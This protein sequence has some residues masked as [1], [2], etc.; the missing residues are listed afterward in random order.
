MTIARLRPSLL[1]GLA[2][3]T[4]AG[5]GARAA[6]LDHIQASQ[7][8][9]LCAHPDMLP[10]SKQSEPPSGFQV[11]L[12]QA[13]ADRLG[14]ELDISW[15]ISRRSASKTGCDLYAGVAR[16]DDAPSKYLKLTDAFMRMESVLVTAAHRPALHSIT[17]LQGMTVGVAPGSVAAH[18]LNQQG[19]RTST[20]FLDESKRLQALLNHAIDAAVVT[21]LSAGWLQQ[22]LQ[23][24]QEDDEKRAENEKHSALNILDAEQLLG[25]RLNYDYAL[26]LRK[27]DQSTLEH[28]NALLAEMKADGS[29]AGLLRH[30][31]LDAAGHIALSSKPIT[32]N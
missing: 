17:D 23:Q 14:V 9:E 4:F 6:S 29:L 25:A 24:Q 31:G 5:T 20:R 30:Y 2:I 7:Q 8:L 18:R 16:I 3:L 28:F 32:T 10:F 12:A 19:I 21:Q 26:G 15:I 13:L 11:E 27:A 1:L 22:Q